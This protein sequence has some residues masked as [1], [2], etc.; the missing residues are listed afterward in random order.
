MWYDHDSDFN[1]APYMHHLHTHPVPKAKLIE[2]ES[3]NKC[4][5]KCRELFGNLAKLSSAVTNVK[6][7]EVIMLCVDAVKQFVLERG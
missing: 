6:T 1:T 5:S 4:V 2:F 3:Q 7:K